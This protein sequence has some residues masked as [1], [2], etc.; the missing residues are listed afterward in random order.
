MFDDKIVQFFSL[1]LEIHR[2]ISNIN[3]YLISFFTV[4][5]VLHNVLRPL[6]VRTLLPKISLVYL[7]YRMN[8]LLFF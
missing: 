1:K 5:F 8:G 7:L 3:K 4:N 6:I 2:Y